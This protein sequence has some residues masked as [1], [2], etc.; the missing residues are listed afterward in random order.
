MSAYLLPAAL[1]ECRNLAFEELA[2][3]QFDWQENFRSID[4]LAEV[5]GL[6]VCG[7][8]DEDEA[9]AILAV[10]EDIFPDWQHGGVY[11]RTPGREGN[12]TA[13]LHMYPRAGLLDRAA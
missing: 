5:F 10:L 13:A 6:E 2:R 8:S 4:L 12:W 7:I 3:C 11:Q 9:E 1:S